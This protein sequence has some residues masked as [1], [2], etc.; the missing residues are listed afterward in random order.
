MYKNETDPASYCCLCDLNLSR[1]GIRE[2]P[3][4]D[5][6]R[7]ALRIALRAG[8][9]F[10][11]PIKLDSGRKVEQTEAVLLKLDL[12]LNIL[13]SHG[14]TAIA[15]GLRP[16][17]ESQP[18]NTSLTTLR[19]ESCALSD[20]SIEQLSR[21]FQP[22]NPANRKL[23]L[24]NKS[25][26][27]ESTQHFEEKERETEKKEHEAQIPARV[28]RVSHPDV[29]ARHCAIQDLDLTNNNFSIDGIASM[30]NNLC[31]FDESTSE[32]SENDSTSV[33][34]A[35][36]QPLQPFRTV[37][38]CNSSLSRLNLSH[39]RIQDEGVAM[40]ANILRA[41]AIHESVLKRRVVDPR[42]GRGSLA[43][44]EL[45]LSNCSIYGVSA[46]YF[47]NNK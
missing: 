8:A 19:L 6:A 45:N 3:S 31:V 36:M 40:I 21:C 41:C 17:D 16:L 29:F 7:E 23:S 47:W 34:E 24:F 28:L 10:V 27:A 4:D 18:P 20:E 22:N 11:E 13:S 38:W 12:S 2:I 43:I 33:L 14:I 26:Y 35:L 44:E 5:A 42:Y 25:H 46:F 9:G 1:T 15:E 32:Q 30:F 37:V 39:N